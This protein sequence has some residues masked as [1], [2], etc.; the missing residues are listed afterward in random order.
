LFYTIKY[1]K[2]RDRLLRS[3]FLLT[4]SLAY[5]DNSNAKEEEE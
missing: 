4:D 5:N 1:L 3:F 2:K